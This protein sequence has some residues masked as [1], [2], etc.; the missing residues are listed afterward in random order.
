MLL[1]LCMINVHVCMILVQSI[2]FQ[3]FIWMYMFMGLVARM[4]NAMVASSS[5]VGGSGTL[6]CGIRAHVATWAWMDHEDAVTEA[7]LPSAQQRSEIYDRKFLENF[8]E[9][10]SKC[11]NLW[12]IGRLIGKLLR[13][14]GEL[15]GRSTDRGRNLW[16][17]S[18]WSS[19]V[20]RS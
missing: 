17:F 18:K 2:L 9:N 11:L 1:P 13:C 10:L 7:A 19:A 6:H 15:D 12:P 3:H 20:S 5:L 16:I 14:S 8:V 4:V